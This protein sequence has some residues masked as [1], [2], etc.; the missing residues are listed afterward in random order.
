M[1]LSE[2]RTA[3]VLITLTC[4]LLAL[5]LTTFAQSPGAATDDAGIFVAEIRELNPHLTDG[6]VAGYAL[7]TVSGDQLDVTLVAKGLPEGTR[8]AHIHG[9]AEDADAPATCPDAS[10]DSNGDGTVDLIETEATAGTTLIPFNAHPAEL[11]ILSETYPEANEQGYLTYQVSVPLAELR[12]AAKETYGIDDLA[13]GQ[14]VIFLHG[15]E[16]GVELPDSVQSLPDVPNTVTV[17]IGCGEVR[18][19]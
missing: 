14:R 18:A 9:F 13:L 12:T 5:V 17:P 1:R 4:I 19:L 16:D 3:A 15:V 11:D 2:N 8:L 10:A 7:L 6:D